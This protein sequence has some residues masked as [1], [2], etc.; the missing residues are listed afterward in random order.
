MN[1][2][3]TLTMNIPTSEYYR[4]CF[5]GDP[6]ILVSQAVEAFLL[7][8]Q[9][10]MISHE[11]HFPFSLKRVSFSLS[12]DLAEKIKWEREEILHDAVSFYLAA[13]PKPVRVENG[14]QIFQVETVT[15]TFRRG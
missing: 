4:L 9:R 15:Q 11:T 1:N 14:K 5:L 8:P 12:A 2:L 7:R 6:Q 3:V 13:H 10:P